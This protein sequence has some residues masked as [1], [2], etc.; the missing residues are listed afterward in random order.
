ML[1][2]IRFGSRYKLWDA[3]GQAIESADG[4][5]AFDRNLLR[6]NMRVHIMRCF[7]G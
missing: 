5:V 1:G 6:Y 4:L 7:L 2:R 3:T